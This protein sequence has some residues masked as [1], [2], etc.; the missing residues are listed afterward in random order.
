MHGLLEEEISRADPTPYKMVKEFYQSCMNQ[1]I[2][3]VRRE[4]INFIRFQNLSPGQEASTSAENDRQFGRVA[5]V[6]RS[7]VAPI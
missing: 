7:Q 3:E 2:I 4:I 6:G 1:P 5:D